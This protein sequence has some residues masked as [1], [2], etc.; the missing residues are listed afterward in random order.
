MKARYGM[1]EV[2]GC[3]RVLAAARLGHDPMPRPSEDE[4]R[5]KHYSRMEQVAAE[6]IAEVTGCVLENGGYCKPCDR[7]GIHVE[8]ESTLFLLVGHLDRRIKVNGAW[9]P[10]EI[11]SAGKSS[12]VKFQREQFAAFPGYAGQECAY[13]ATEGKPG[14]YWV[15]ERDS[16][17]ALKYV[18]NDEEGVLDSLGFAKIQLPVTFDQ[19]E[20]KLNQVEL[21]VQSGQLPAGEASDECWWCGYRYLCVKEEKDSKPATTVSDG[22]L[23]A[24]AGEYRYALELEKLV[25]EIKEEAK[26]VLLGYSKASGIDKYRVAGLSVSYRGQKTKKYL[27]Q[28]KIKS[29]Y[30]EVFD[31]CQAETKLFDDY[32]IRRVKEDTNA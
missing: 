17:Q 22:G 18:V 24:A 32:T 6:Q 3:P 11:K 13:L 4:E 30:P 5:L 28:G 20:D 12:W 31:A 26:G 10:V 23:V 27:D 1:S 8:L 25:E 21:M 16:G 29:Q 9:Y 7:N 15:I 14:V 2:G 19:I